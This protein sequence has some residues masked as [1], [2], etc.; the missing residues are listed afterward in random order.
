MYDVHALTD[1]GTLIFAIVSSYLAMR[2]GVSDRI[3]AIEKDVAYLKGQF[4][5]WDG[6]ERR[7]R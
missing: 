5:A 2:R 7:K 4:D 3:T 1:I 6:R